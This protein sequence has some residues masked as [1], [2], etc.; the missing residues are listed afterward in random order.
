MFLTIPITVR[1]TCLDEILALRFVAV[2]I[3][4]R[5]RRATLDRGPFQKQQE[6]HLQDTNFAWEHRVVGFVKDS[7][8]NVISDWRRGGDSITPKLLNC[9]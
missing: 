8:F 7:K 4:H 1:A 5:F 2:C 6:G 9:K 3:Q